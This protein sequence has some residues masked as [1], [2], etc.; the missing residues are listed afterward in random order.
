MMTS[1][2]RFSFSA[3]HF[4]QQKNWSAEKNK[5]EF[6]K[7]FSQYGHGH[8]YVVECNW[9]TTSPQQQTEL[10]QLTKSVREIFDHHHLNFMFHEFSDKVPTTENLALL[11]KQK[12]EES[13]KIKPQLATAKLLNLKVYETPEIWVE[14]APMV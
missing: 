14:I 10:D 5:N 8:D 2:F 13:A 11:I 6:G 4:Y 1:C 7:C 12:L 3:A 9:L